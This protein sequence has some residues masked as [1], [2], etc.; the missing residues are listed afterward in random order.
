MARVD[1][2][3][4]YVVRPTGTGHEVLQLRR[5]SNRYLAGEWAFPGGRVEPGETAAAAALREL[6]EETGIGPSRIG[7]F[8]HVSHVE[9]AYSP[10]WDGI[11]HRA[12]F[13]A[14]IGRD[15]PIRLNDEH[16][17]LRW[18]TR[19]QFGKHVL[20]PGERAALAEIW[21]EHLRPSPAKHL[22]RLDPRE[23]ARTMPRSPAV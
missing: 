2:V 11:R 5:S 1:F 4:S 12:S 14:V 16:D 3:A 17:A 20:W 22:R 13:V 23:I 18:I 15:V 19:R 7:E 8:A 6:A 21:R 10:S 9:V